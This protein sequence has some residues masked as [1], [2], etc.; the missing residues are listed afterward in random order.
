MNQNSSN[1]INSSG[2][3]KKIYIHINRINVYW[4]N[5]KLIDSV[6]SIPN[7]KP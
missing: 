6:G 3:N 7:S 4:M 2:K 5:P 1:P